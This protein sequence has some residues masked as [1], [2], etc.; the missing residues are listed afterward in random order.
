MSIKSATLKS[1]GNNNPGLVLVINLIIP[2]K[3]QAF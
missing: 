1:Q 3:F 2:L